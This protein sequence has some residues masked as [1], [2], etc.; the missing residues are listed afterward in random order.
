MCPYFGDTY[1]EKLIC[2]FINKSLCWLRFCNTAVEQ[3]RLAE[4]K[5]NSVAALCLR[6]TTTNL[7]DI[8]S[9]LKYREYPPILV[10]QGNNINSA[11]IKI[12]QKP[13]RKIIIVL[14]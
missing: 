3:T 12:N 7:E 8:K 10:I 1:M 6:F 4:D 5:L 13:Y 11:I 9:I 14:F 2:G